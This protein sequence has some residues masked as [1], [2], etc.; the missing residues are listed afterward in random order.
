LRAIAYR[1]QKKDQKKLN[2]NGSSKVGA[3]EVGD[4]E[5]L[6][7]ADEANGGA[8]DITVVAPALPSSGSSRSK[9]AK[10]SL[11]VV[12]VIVKAHVPADVSS[13]RPQPQEY[14]QP[15]PG[16]TRKRV[17]SGSGLGDLLGLLSSGSGARQTEERSR[18]QEGAPP[19]QKVARLQQGGTLVRA[20]CV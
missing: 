5:S 20:A 9:S 2:N 1:A 19:P 7:D 18:A 6:E 13:A 12:P 14:G 4:D 3:I 15:A 16:V 11:V 8:V 17:S 10:P